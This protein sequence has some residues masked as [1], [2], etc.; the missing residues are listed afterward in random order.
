MGVEFRCENCGKLLN[1]DA[2]PGGS[3]KCP[4]CRKKMAV[5]AGLASLPRPQTPGGAAPPP[6]PPPGEPEEEEEMDGSDDAVM[7]VM[8]QVM[9]WVISA[10]FHLG[11]MLVMM[12]IALIVLDANKPSK[13]K[14]QEKAPIDETRRVEKK[15]KDPRPKSPIKGPARQNKR[16]VPRSRNVSMVEMDSTGTGRKAEISGVIGKGAAGGAPGGKLAPFGPPRVG[17][18][19]GFFGIRAQGDFIIYVIDKSGSMFAG[20]A[21]DLLRLKLAA[22]VGDLDESQHFHLIFF[23]PKEPVEK[24]PAKLVPA[25]ADNAWQAAGFLEE[26]TPRGETQVLPA[27]KRAFEVFDGVRGEGKK[28][29]YLLS[30]GDFEGLGRTS[31]EYKGKVG[32]QG[33]VEWLKD[34]NR[35][36]EGDGVRDV[37]IHTFLYKPDNLEAKEVMEKIADEHGGKFTLVSQ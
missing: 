35:D 22:S 5:P 1:V 36:T 33:V 19:D 23:G 12:F 13:L 8:A 18:G 9:P 30:D 32:N 11:L 10:F 6:P 14:E 31:N 3:V 25:T 28:L 34:H 37:E 29:I 7:K 24:K 27:L 2:S 15:V 16:P 20:G 4:H 26:L 17:G 21:F